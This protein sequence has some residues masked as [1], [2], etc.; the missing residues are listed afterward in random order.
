MRAQNTGLGT[1]VVQPTVL[2]QVD[3]GATLDFLNRATTITSLSGAGTILN[4]GN[5][6][7]LISANF[8]GAFN[9]AQSLVTTGAVTLSGNSGYTGTTTVQSGTLNITN[10]GALGTSASGTTVNSGGTLLITGS[11]PTLLLAD[12]LTIS[13]T[14][15]GGIGAV[16]V[17]P[18]AS[19]GNQGVNLTGGVTLAADATITV[20]DRIALSFNTGGIA[21]GSSTLTFASEGTGNSSTFVNSAISGTGGLT[22]TGA[23]VLNLNG[24]NTFTGPVNLNGGTLTLTGSTAVQTRWRSS[25]RQAQDWTSST[26][27][28][29]DRWRVLASSRWA[30]AQS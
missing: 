14:G 29:S 30:M 22:K 12:A 1:L 25:R 6:T 15:N 3:A 28:P 27:K 10:A 9:G 13:G 17:E 7:T 4:A 5:T 24:T 11:S 8:S 18:N 23:G 16:R 20:T 19:P 26:A 2:T 21:L